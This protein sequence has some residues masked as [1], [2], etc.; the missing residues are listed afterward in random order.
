MD[1]KTIIIRHPNLKI[2][3]NLPQ[4]RIETSGRRPKIKKKYKPVS[5]IT[6]YYVLSTNHTV[7]VIMNRRLVFWVM[8]P[9]ILQFVTNAWKSSSP[10]FQ[11]NRIPCIWRRHTAPKIPQ[12]NTNKLSVVLHSKTPLELHIAKVIIPLNT[13]SKLF[14][15]YMKTISPY[16][17]ENTCCF[18][19][20]AQSARTA[21]GNNFC[22]STGRIYNTYKHILWAKW[23]DF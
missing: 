2:K 1:A 6:I 13:M 9:S 7:Q 8:T 4:G 14:V 11:G 20:N 10:P 19:L 3:G 22:L 17:P 23:G 12:K 15:Y 21:Q 16:A 18:N 5:D